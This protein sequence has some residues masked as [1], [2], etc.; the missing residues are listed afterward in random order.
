MHEKLDVNNI[1]LAAI[2]SA[3]G[4]LLPVLFHLVGLGPVFMPMYLPL[5]AGAYL[6]T[7]RN[8]LIMGFLTPLISAVLT[9]M[10]PFYPPIAPLMIVQ[11]S[12][13]CVIISFAEHKF[14]PMILI[15]L[16]IAIITDRVLLVLYYAVI[17]NNKIY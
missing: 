2:F 14:K 16:L 6:L 15:P 5:A 13:F 3:F 10:P 11:L 8:A 1:L 17:I 9:G 4:I 7:K 12:I